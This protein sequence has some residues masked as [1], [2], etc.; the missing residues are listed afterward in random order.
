[1]KA[2]GATEIFVEVQSGRK[3]NRPKLKELLDSVEKRLVSEV[4]VT[5]VDRLAR[6]LPKLRQVIDVF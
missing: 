1:V 5:R 3:D 2:A 4:I 6:S